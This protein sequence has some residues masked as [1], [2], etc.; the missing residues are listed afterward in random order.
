MITILGPGAG[1]NGYAYP[2]DIHSFVSLG[3][4]TQIE[5]GAPIYFSERVIRYT[6]EELAKLLTHEIIHHL[7]P[8]D[9]SRDEIF[10]ESLAESVMTGTHSRVLEFGITHGV[11]IRKDFISGIGLARLT[12]K[13]AMVNSP[14][15]WGTQ[16]PLKENEAQ[17]TAD[18][19]TFVGYPNIDY[20]GARISAVSD[21]VQAGMNEAWIAWSRAT[22]PEYDWGSGWETKVREKLAPEQTEAI[23]REFNPKNPWFKLER[24]P[25]CKSDYLIFRPYCSDP[26]SL[27]ELFDVDWVEENGGSGR[28]R[29]ADLGVMNAAL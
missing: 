17:K 21:M 20:S 1:P 8:P 25:G 6:S 15:Y 11:V 12:L 18:A 23:A 28:D 14:D 4:M 29:T 7:V 16:V 9:A 3:A 2:Q 19:A 5:M 27:Q 13:R 22:Q 26:L 24:Q 10:V